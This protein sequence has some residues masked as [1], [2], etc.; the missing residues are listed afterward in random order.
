MPREIRKRKWA[1]IT[2]AQKEKLILINSRKPA[3]YQKFKRAIQSLKS[4]EEKG[5]WTRPSVT[6][7]GSHRP[8]PLWQSV[9]CDYF[10]IATLGL[11]RP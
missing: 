5:F 2:K 11:Y 9:L 6:S 4:Q 10:C 3:E 7:F 1:K 8:R